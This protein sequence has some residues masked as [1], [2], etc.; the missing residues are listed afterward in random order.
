MLCPATRPW[1][2]L[3]SS[4]DSEVPTNLLAFGETHRL[5]VFSTNLFNIIYTIPM[6]IPVIKDCWN[7]F[8]QCSRVVAFALG[9]PIF[10]S[11]ISTILHS[12]HKTDWFF[13]I[14]CSKISVKR[15]TDHSN[16]EQTSMSSVTRIKLPVKG[17][18]QKSMWFSSH[19]SHSLYTI[20]ILYLLLQRRIFFSGKMWKRRALPLEV[21]LQATPDSISSCWSRSICITLWMYSFLKPGVG[22]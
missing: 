18:D 12:I 17:L 5:I 1:P 19:W 22:L 9:W 15:R 2:C 7:G 20:I 3:S 6:N 4:T 16:T 21:R 8:G 13:I 11:P 14:P 10:V